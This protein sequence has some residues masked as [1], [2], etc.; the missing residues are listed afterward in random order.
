MGYRE[1]AQSK[2]RMAFKLIGNLAL[3]CKLLQKDSSTFNFQTRTAEENPTRKSTVKVVFTSKGRDKNAENTIR[4]EILMLAEDVDD[5]TIYDKIVINNETWN[6]VPPYTN[7]DYTI[8]SG[9]SRLQ[10]ASNG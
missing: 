8:T 10:G 3:E 5:F 9:V 7:D 1:L 2:A 6:I 4:G